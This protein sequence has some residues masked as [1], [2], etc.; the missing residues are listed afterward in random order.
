[1]EY[2][3]IKNDRNKK[4]ILLPETITSIFDS[5]RIE[6]KIYPLKPDFI[7]NQYEI[8][9]K[10]Y[11]YSK[12]DVFF[13]SGKNQYSIS[14]LY[15]QSMLINI[16]KKVDFGSI[17]SKNGIMKSYFF[18]DFDSRI[19]E[20][21]ND[22]NLKIIR[23]YSWLFVKLENELKSLNR[24]EIKMNFFT[25][26]FPDYFI[27]GNN[28]KIINKYLVNYETLGKL[29]YHFENVIN[30]EEDEKILSEY[31]EKNLNKYVELK[32]KIDRIKEGKSGK[33]LDF[34]STIS[35]GI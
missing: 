22:K 13:I 8:M 23:N 29:L 21:L 15:P 10:L 16:G 11:K 31:K 18:S 25:N 6:N 34:I 1:M 3:K 9:G 17:M 26:H 33:I 30:M 7:Y 27:N 2:F 24:R 35:I 28:G 32:E 19:D 20:L 12:K 14:S 5:I 4:I